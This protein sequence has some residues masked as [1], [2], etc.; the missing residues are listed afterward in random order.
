[1]EDREESSAKEGM[2]CGGGRGQLRRLRARDEIPV[3]IHLRV[4]V[5]V[6][7]SVCV[8]VWDGQ[9]MWERWSVF[10]TGRTKNTLPLASSTAWANQEHVT[11]SLE[12]SMGEPRTRYH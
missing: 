1:M 5:C 10:M 12:H 8:S 4:G 6:C 7:V 3:Q 2:L 9:S 11:T